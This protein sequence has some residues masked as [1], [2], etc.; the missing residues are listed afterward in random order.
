MIKKGY[1]ESKEIAPFLLYYLADDEGVNILAASFKV[2]VV[3]PALE[4]VNV[5]GLRNE[6]TKEVDLDNC[7]LLVPLLTQGTSIKY[8][9]NWKYVG[10]ETIYPVYPRGTSII[11]NQ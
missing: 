11:R 3:L 4:W 1:L 6:E 2:L 9:A 5:L 10:S 8:I 7:Y